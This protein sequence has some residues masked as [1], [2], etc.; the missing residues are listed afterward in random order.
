M[1]IV[2]NCKIYATTLKLHYQ[3]QCM[4]GMI[5]Q[6]LID[7]FCNFIIYIFNQVDLLSVEFAEKP[8]PLEH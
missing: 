8:V 7:A 2:D 3:Y 4:N 1:N 5:A 6:L